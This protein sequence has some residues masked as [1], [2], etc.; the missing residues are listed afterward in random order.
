MYVLVVREADGNETEYDLEGEVVLGRDE[1]ADIRLG[2]GSVSRKHARIFVEDGLCYIE[3]MGSSNGTSIGG[4]PVVGAVVL[5]IGREA[6]LGAFVVWVED[7]DAP[8]DVSG[9]VGSPSTVAGVPAMDGGTYRGPAPTGDGAPTLEGLGGVAYGQTFELGTRNSVG[10]T[11]GNT[12]VLPDPSM[13]RG[14]AEVILR[15]SEII[16][17]DLGSSNGTFVNDQQITQQA[18]FEGDIVR[19]GDV[20]LAVHAGD[21]M[22]APIMAGGDDGAPPPSIRRGARRPAKGGGGGRK[23]LLL[24]GGVAVVGIIAIA[25]VLKPKPPPPKPP[26][27]GGK[28]AA[29]KPSSV[30]EETY[31]K[32][33]QAKAAE[34]S[35]EWAMA[36]KLYQQVVDLD[37]INKDARDSL[38]RVQLNKKMGQIFRDA[39]SKR[40]LADDQQA[41]ELFMGIDRKSHYY[42][43]AQYEVS[44]LVKDM[45]KKYAGDCLGNYRARRW[46]DVLRTCR[47]HEDLACHCQEFANKEVTR[48]L[49]DAERHQ[50]VPASERWVCPIAYAS[51]VPCARQVRGD[52]AEAV[53]GRYQ[54]KKIQESMVLYCKGAAIKG[55]G[56][57]KKI[58]DKYSHPNRDQA[59]DISSSMK[60]VEGKWKEGSGLILKGDPEEAGRVW[61]SMLQA[62]GRIVPDGAESYYRV[63][64]GKELRKA[65]R[66][67]GQFEMNQERY[68][69]AFDWAMKGMAVGKG[70]PRIKELIH[71]LEQQG[72]VELRK[73]V[74]C[75]EFQKI[76]A[77]TRADPPSPTHQQ[78]LAQLER[79]NCQ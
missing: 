41:L 8:E 28:G 54:H 37:P 61:Q 43:Q 59:V 6:E 34:E 10:R 19:F 73:A 20:E 78:A 70:D 22:A 29:G 9:A 31:R 65:Y 60:V 38:R 17:R 71:R 75:G 24:V 53:A 14:H 23:K 62:D 79:R 4:N 15:G 25:A 40:D 46:K 67:K 30:N 64:A 44:G 18:V 32:V 42:G 27:V 36:E 77:M 74:T 2:D 68:P 76:K 50:R 12:I 13:S 47:Q 52:C 56:I 11:E 51:W 33:R 66:D 7:P 35:Q 69:Q 49:R 5:E 45:V 63:E 58:T 1:G 39:K 16:V 48:Y 21:E 26:P 3:D 72:A 55:M 57:L